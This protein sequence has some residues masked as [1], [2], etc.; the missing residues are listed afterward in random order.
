MMKY[1]GYQATLKYD[2]ESQVFYGEVI[3]TRDVIFFE[4][5]S[6]EELNKEFR[7]SID[8]YLAMCAERG[9]EPDKPFSGR[10]PLR[11]S[12]EV[13]RAA[14]AVAKSEGKSLNAWLAETIERAV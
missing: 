3:S 1:K 8:D 12:P 9:Q 2:D 11:I 14:N 6:V 4:G 7:F 10:I 13:H 5:T